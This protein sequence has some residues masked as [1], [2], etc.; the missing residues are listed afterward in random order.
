MNEKL[1][2]YIKENFPKTVRYNPQDNG[3]LIGLPKP[4]NVPSIEGRFQEM[5][6]WDTY[7]LN[8][9]LILMGETEQAKN[10][11]DNILY[12][13]DKYG[14]MPNGNRTFYLHNSQPPFSTLMVEE[15]FAVTGDK[16]WLS[17]AYKTLTKEYEF[18]STRRSTPIGLTQYKGERDMAVAD[19]MA[20]GFLERIGNR[21]ENITDERLAWQYVA[22]CESGWDINPRFDFHVEDWCSVELNSLLLRYE[23]NMGKF[24]EILGIDG[25]TQWQERADKRKAL[26][27]KYM[28]KDGIFYDYDFTNDKISDKFTYAGI[29]GM[30]MGVISESQA[31][32]VKDNF[33]RIETEYGVAATEKMYDKGIYHYQWQYPNGWAPTQ[34]LAINAFLN[35][36]YIDDAK[37]IAQKYVNLVETNFEKTNNLW[38][39]YNVVTGGVDVEDEC[40]QRHQ[41]MPPMMG[42]T[43][44]VY[45]E[46]LSVL[47][48][49][50]K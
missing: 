13:I 20:E 34:S 27:E 50:G 5:Y 30:A 18:W 23:I 10:N 12:L 7:F 3:N 39:K 21:P 22:I 35:Y 4:Y 37:R 19:G 25:K 45:I 32:A 47:E 42:W 24:C 1:N 29:Y 46:A 11:V 43:S 28:L 17:A 38:E 44:G 26:M 16:E 41:T 6:Y 48:K 36:G 8:R 2:K 31:K 49:Y 15:I 14:Y 9:G 33:Y 40:S